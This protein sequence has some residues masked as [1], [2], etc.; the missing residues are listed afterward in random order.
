MSDRSSLPAS[1]LLAYLRLLAG[2]AASLALSS[3]VTACGQRGP[4]VL[5]PKTALAAAVIGAGEATAIQ[6][7][8]LNGANETTAIQAAGLNGANETTAI[9]AG[10]PQ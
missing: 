6:A 9:Q 10:Y 4:L 8:A 1:R 2:V 3:C 7:A 5:P